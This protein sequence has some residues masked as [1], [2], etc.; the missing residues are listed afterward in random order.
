MKYFKICVE[1]DDIDPSLHDDFDPKL[2]HKPVVRYHK[3][4]VRVVGRQE[5]VRGYHKPVGGLVW[6]RYRTRQ[7]RT[8]ID[9][10][11]STILDDIEEGE[12]H[13][14]TRRTSPDPEWN[15]TRLTPDECLRVMAE[16]EWWFDPQG[17]RWVWGERERE[18]SVCV[19]TAYRR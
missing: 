7:I 6:D 18:V 14:F 13:R 5:G 8:S 4:V 2:A 12:R 11:M 17:Q 9:V 15:Y 1:Y 19:R 3:P 10:D 16:C